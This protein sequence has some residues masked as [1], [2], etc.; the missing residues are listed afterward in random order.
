MGRA[1]LDLVF[2]KW[3]GGLTHAGAYARKDIEAQFDVTFTDKQ[4][5]ILLDEVESDDERSKKEVIEDVVTNMSQYE[6]EDQFWQEQL[7][8]AAAKRDLD[9]NETD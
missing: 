6:E 9:R 4:W 7:D 3:A 2:S 1:E 5:K 8:A